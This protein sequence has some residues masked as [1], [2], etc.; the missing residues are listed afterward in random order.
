[1]ALFDGARE[2]SVDPLRVIRPMTDEVTPT[3]RPT[4]SPWASSTTAGAWSISTNEHTRREAGP[5]SQ[6]ALRASPVAERKIPP[7]SKLD[8]LA[9]RFAATLVALSLALGVGLPATTTPVE[10]AGQTVARDGFTRQ[11]SSSW[12]RAAAGGRYSVSRGAR[13][14]VRGSTGYVSLRRPGNAFAMLRRA[15]ARDTDMRFTV[16]LGRAA[17]GNRLRILAIARQ[18]GAGSRYEAQVVVKR[19][20]LSV[21]IALRS[22][23]KVRTLVSTRKIGYDVTGSTRVNMRLRVAGGVPTT[24]SFKAWPVGTSE[25]DWQAQAQSRAPGLARAGSVGVGVVAPRGMGRF[26]ARVGFDDLRVTSLRAPRITAAGPRITDVRVTDITQDA[27]TIRWTLSE[28]ATGLVEFGTAGFGRQTTKERS[29]RYSQHIQTITGLRPGT[30]YRFRVR[31]TN[32]SGATSVSGG[33]TF[34]T[35]GSAPAAP[36]ATPRPTSAPNATPRPTPRP[37]ANPTPRPT[38]RPTANPTPRPPSNGNTYEVPSSID[39]SGGSDVSTA[40]ANFVKSVPDG[41]TIVFRSGGT[42]RMERGLKLLDRHN[43]VLD[44][45]GATFRA[46][47]CGMDDSPIV[48]SDYN[49]GIVI[50]DFTLR[51]DNAGGGTSQSHN[52]GCE[53]Q[54]GVTIFQSTD[55]EID[56]VTISHTN[57]DCLYMD[58]GGSARVWVDGVYFH[59]S[60][61]T[62]NGRQ[63]VSVIGARN[64]T[65]NNVQFDKIAMNVLDVEPNTTSGGGVNI[66]FTN[67]TVGTYSIDAD[68]DQFLFAMSG[69]NGTV[70]NIRVEGNRVTGGTLRSYAGINRSSDVVFRNN[71]STVTAQ[72]DPVVDFR[73]VDGLTVTGNTQP[74]RSGNFAAIR[75]STNVTYNP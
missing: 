23:N 32:R 28:A 67:N 73:Y 40:V 3:T 19:G 25:P 62:S 36:Q 74:L 11:S 70:R 12:G 17:L 48:I 57:G 54:A 61:C 64:V 68:W 58:Y 38:P 21:G 30:T 8:R 5:Q 7:M 51:G 44:G 16:R 13:W 39:S 53:Q 45:N 1:L 2:A 9:P 66:T 35:A 15:Q 31:S 10:S 43:L 59:D 60:V 34:T 26:P 18:T 42:Y 20:E 52:S 47:G 29:F 56:N 65:V 49:T 37:T 71:T 50:R 33:A 27:A 72:N 69:A 14:S 55:I 6:G 41:S 63:G 46:Y 24:I 22:R 75:D 4:P